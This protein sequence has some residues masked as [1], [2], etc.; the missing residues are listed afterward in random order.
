MKYGDQTHQI[1]Q[2]L[3]KHW[4]I[5]TSDAAVKDKVPPMPSF[6]YK[7]GNSL[8]RL[9][10]IRQSSMKDGKRVSRGT[11]KCGCCNYCKY[12]YEGKSIILKD[13]NRTKVH[14]KNGNCLTRHVIYLAICDT[15]ENYY[16]GMT[17]RFLK[18]RMYDHLYCIKRNDG[19]N[20]LSRHISN[21]EPCKSFK[22]GIIDVVSNN[23]RGGN[24]KAIVGEK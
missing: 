23:P 4:H 7:A 11:T 1:K 18:N 13:R 24:V 8:H 21:N 9:I 12:I 15:C 17:D 20:A 19:N 5:L 6:V 10:E 14:F 2:I 16:V 22:F 3:A